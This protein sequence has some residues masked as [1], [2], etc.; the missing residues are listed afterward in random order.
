MKS[1]IERRHMARNEHAR[2][3]YQ[4]GNAPLRENFGRSAMWYDVV[5]DEMCEA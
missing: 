3:L 5:E 2:A 4:R 1:E